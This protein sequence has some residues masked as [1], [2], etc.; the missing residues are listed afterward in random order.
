[1]FEQNTRSYL[2]NNIYILFVFQNTFIIE[3]KGK[4]DVF[5]EKSL[6]E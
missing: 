5:G 3:I 1:M 6:L 4:G 2:T